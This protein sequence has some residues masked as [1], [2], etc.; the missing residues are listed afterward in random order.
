MASNA[1]GQPRSRSHLGLSCKAPICLALSASTPCSMAS[2]SSPRPA[3]GRRRLRFIR[4]LA[5]RVR[6]QRIEPRF[7]LGGVEC[8]MLKRGIKLCG[9]HRPNGVNS[10]MTV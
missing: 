7:V 9:N 1:R 10:L 6:C 3:G 5:P 4:G 2:P 8:A